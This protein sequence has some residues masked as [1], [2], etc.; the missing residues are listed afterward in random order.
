MD[1]QAKPLLRWIIQRKTAAGM[2][3]TLSS[4]WDLGQHPVGL[5][6]CGRTRRAPLLPDL[7][8]G[9]SLDVVVRCGEPIVAVGAL[10]LHHAGRRFPGLGVDRPRGGL[11]LPS[12]PVVHGLRRYMASP[13]RD[14]SLAT[15]RAAAPRKRRRLR[16][17]AQLPHL[18]DGAAQ[19]ST[20]G[21]A[22]RE[23]AVTQ[24]PEL[25]ACLE[26]AKWGHGPAR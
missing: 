19:P 17:V 18:H 23:R 22:E 13:S 26:R 3:A 21:D 4:V 24:H 25:R 7:A 9:A 11:V 2:A 1:I 10:Q 20:P 5:G 8:I 16:L 14:K 15:K 12:A 6:Q